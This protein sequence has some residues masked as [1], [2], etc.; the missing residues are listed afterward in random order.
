MLAAV[1][2]V[3][4]LFGTQGKTGAG[5]SSRKLFR[6]GERAPTR[7]PARL[8]TS[9]GNFAFVIVLWILFIA[10][11]V[12]VASVVVIAAA[13]L[14]GARAVSV[15]L[16]ATAINYFCGGRARGF[17]DLIAIASHSTHKLSASDRSGIVAT[18]NIDSF[19]IHG[20]LVPRAP[21]VISHRGRCDSLNRL[22]LRFRAL[23]CSKD[24]K[25]SVEC[26]RVWRKKA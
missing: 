8:A 21:I 11:G 1:A 22:T 5:G 6:S 4:Q 7:G 17:V 24:I 13:A 2:A 3:P 15:Q 9:I 12:T 23:C 18:T 10:G 19:R 26:A 25:S 20:G 16:G 14:E